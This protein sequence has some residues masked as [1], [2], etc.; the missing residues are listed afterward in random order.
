MKLVLT[1]DNIEDTPDR[2][3]TVYLFI[4][5]EHLDGIS[6]IIDFIVLAM[7]SPHTC[8]RV[9]ERLGFEFGTLQRR[10]DD[11]LGE[12]EA[13]ILALKIAAQHPDHR[14]TTEYIKQQMPGYIPL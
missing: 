7:V 13:R 8:H 2:T 9:E 10:E 5:I 4:H 6:K 14:A 11:R 3:A 12:P 1:F